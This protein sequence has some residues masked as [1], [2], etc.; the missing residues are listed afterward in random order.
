MDHYDVVRGTDA[1]QS[2]GNVT[3]WTA[4]GLSPSTTYS[5]KVRACDAA[6]NC[7]AYGAT[8]S[9]TTSSG[10][11]DP[12]PCGSLPKHVLTGYWQNFNNGATVQRIRDV[13]ANYDLI[14]VA[15]ADADPSRPGGITFTLDSGL[16]AGWAAT[17][18]PSSRPTSPPSTR[19]ARRSSCPSVARTARS[20]SPT[21]TAASNFAS[22]AL[23]VLREYGF[24]GIDIDLENGVNAQY[25]GQALRSLRSSFGSGLIIT[26]APQ[27]IDMQA[28]VVRVLQAGAGDQGHPDHR[29]RAVL[30]LRLR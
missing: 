21:P 24:D 12:P 1:P 27:T 29:Q 4:T 19:P 9:G 26:M 8:V 18:W 11:T 30:Q 15:F 7:S 2:V 23:S 28:T 14:A 5:F 17:P 16:S 20:R 10:P 25:M 6:G 3:S 22:S 13:P